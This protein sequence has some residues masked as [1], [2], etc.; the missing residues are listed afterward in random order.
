M[1][2]A[3]VDGGDGEGQARDDGDSEVGGAGSTGFEGID[4]A[5]AA[6]DPGD[7]GNQRSCSDAVHGDGSQAAISTSSAS[8]AAA[9]DGD[10]GLDATSFQ[11]AANQLGWSSLSR[12]EFLEKKKAFGDMRTKIG[13]YYRKEHRSLTNND[14]LQQVLLKTTKQRQSKPHRLTAVQVFQSK[15]YRDKIK[16]EADKDWEAAQADYKQ[17][18][19]S[20]DQS[21]ECKPPVRVAINYST[22]KRLLEEQDEEFRVEMQNLADQGYEESKR[23]WE[24]GK[25]VVEVERTEE[26]QAQAIKKWGPAVSKI[27]G[28]L[29]SDLKMGASTAFFGRVDGKVK[30]YWVHH[31]KTPSGLIWPKFDPA[32]YSAAEAALIRFGRA[33]FPND[34]HSSRIASQTSAG[35]SS[36]QSVNPSIGT[37]MAEPGQ[38]RKPGPGRNSVGIKNTSAR[39]RKKSSESN[40]NQA[41]ATNS[42]AS[43][44]SGTPSRAQDNF[45]A[46]QNPAASNDS[47]EPTALDHVHSS[48]LPN[49][50]NS[51]DATVPRSSPSSSDDTTVPN[52]HTSVPNDHTSVPNDHTSVPNNLSPNS[53][54]GIAPDIPVHDDP[55]PSGINSALSIAPSN[56]MDV[57]EPAWSHPKEKK[58]W[59]EMRHFI[60]AWGDEF[61][62]KDQEDWMVD[63][64]A[65][66][67]TF[68]E[69]EEAFRFTEDN[70]TLRSTKELRL[71][72][73][74][75]KRGRPEWVDLVVPINQVD[76]LIERTRTWWEDILPQRDSD[77]DNWSP[78]DSV[79][80]KNGIWRF[81]CALV[82]VLVLVLGEEKISERTD[83]QRQQLSD[84]VL[85]AQ[86]VESTLGRVIEYGIWPPKAKRKL[87]GTEKPGSP[88]RRKTR[89]SVGKKNVTKK[90]GKGKGTK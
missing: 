3:T 47:L 36:S 59:P 79:S 17:W 62:G 76:L 86:E 66:M 65:L 38:G 11:Q 84:W 15:Y 40:P 13:N 2:A 28:A 41:S 14:I 77:D 43:G 72:K 16:P 48:P 63:L 9:G 46:R 85:L 82:W 74:W 4:T 21:E 27:T 69:Y 6:S 12:Q 26:Q 53:A 25:T 58:F 24:K 1:I 39:S 67:E 19:A 68:I 23:D 49:S 87:A 5:G 80:G 30:V 71:M 88:K 83:E 90:T 52:D 29:A 7:S 61:S 45:P 60:K 64:E 42:S 75:E 51:L 20:G 8:A 56:P 22:A 54:S 31:G 81:V 35:A 18:Q 73:E 78:L 44:V 50:P 32:G 34:G 89:A 70:G 55:F 37:A 57:D 33:M 10:S